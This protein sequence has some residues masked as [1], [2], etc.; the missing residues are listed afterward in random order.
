MGTL[1]CLE[2]QA[3]RTTLGGCDPHT[4]EPPGEMGSQGIATLVNCYQRLWDQRRDALTLGTHTSSSAHVLMQRCLSQWLW[5]SQGAH[6][7][8]KHSP[9]P[10]EGLPK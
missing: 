7:E 9:W 2:T 5:A 8:G 1:L 6:C 10:W 3:L 4:P